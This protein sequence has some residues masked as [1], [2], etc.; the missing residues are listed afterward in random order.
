MSLPA[1]TPVSWQS[2]DRFGRELS[3]HI[4]NAGTR[5]DIVIAVGRGGYV[6]ARL[7][8]DF[9]H[10]DRLTGIKVEHYVATR[11]QT[12][13]VIR[14]PLNVDVRGLDVLVVDDVNDS[15]ETLAVVLRYS[16]TFEP[17]A[18]KFLSVSIPRP[19]IA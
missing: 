17:R 15:G 9:P 1:C 14:Y 7:V 16:E 6:P 4:L 8:C 18:P 13:V 10:L 11:K 5:P 3:R 19:V 12:E 2:V